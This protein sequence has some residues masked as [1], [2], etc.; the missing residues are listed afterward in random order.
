M[1]RPERE[2]ARCQTTAEVRGHDLYRQE[3][4]VRR[5]VGHADATPHHKDDNVLVPALVA[6]RFHDGFAV[7]PG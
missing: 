5:F 7:L 2:V 3:V 1:G 4:V 6:S